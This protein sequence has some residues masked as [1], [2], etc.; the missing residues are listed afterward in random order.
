MNDERMDEI[1]AAILRG[2]VL[3]S[4][5]IVLA[6]GIWHLAGSGGQ[7][8][9]YHHFSA[10]RGV[11]SLFALPMPEVVILAGLLLLTAT[12]AA[13]VIFSLVAFAMERDWTYVAIT[14]VVL[15]VLGYS[16][17]TGL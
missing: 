10:T 13:R 16:I 3:L 8:P 14:A 9:P 17:L 6:G 15:G 4:A 1:I 5:A 11:R 7:P 2:G 12:P